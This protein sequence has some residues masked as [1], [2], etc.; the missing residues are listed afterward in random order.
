MPRKRRAADDDL[1]DRIFM[2]LMP[3]WAM[4]LMAMYGAL[5]MFACGM[6]FGL[7]DDDS[8]YLT[9]TTWVVVAVPVL[10]LLAMVFLTIVARII[11][12]DLEGA[13]DVVVARLPGALFVLSPVGLVLG[14]LVA[15][16]LGRAA[17]GLGVAESTAWRWIIFP[18]A[19]LVC[20]GIA[21][22]TYLRLNGRSLLP[23]W[24]PA[25]GGEL[26]DPLAG[27]AGQDFGG[28]SGTDFGG[29]SGD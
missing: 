14:W 18:V 15:I 29:D 7:P 20:L 24:R 21:S 5:F 2:P 3:I 28:G 17:T 10:T 9:A 26:G 6:L 4:V 27:D 8:A 11:G 23:P 13:F 12:E 22:V 19:G 25:P 16:P 1:F